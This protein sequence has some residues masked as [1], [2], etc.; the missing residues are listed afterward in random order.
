LP[1]KAD[2]LTAQ[3]A[4]ILK[5]DQDMTIDDSVVVIQNLVVRAARPKP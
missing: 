5:I 3:I 2:E 4:D 1:D